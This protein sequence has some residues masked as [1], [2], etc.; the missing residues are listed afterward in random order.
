[1]RLR[2]RCR[3]EA[4]FVWVEGVQRRKQSEHT[5]E[6]TRYSFN[7]FHGFQKDKKTKNVFKSKAAHAHRHQPVCALKPRV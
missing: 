5:S 1:M 2:G 7:T 4:E 6:P 3:L